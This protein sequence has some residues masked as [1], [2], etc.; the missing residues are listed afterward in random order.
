MTEELE[1]TFGFDTTLNHVPYISLLTLL[2][3]EKESIYK[4]RNFF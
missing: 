1:K 4:S 3:F 2:E